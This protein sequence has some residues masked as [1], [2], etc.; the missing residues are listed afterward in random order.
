MSKIYSGHGIEPLLEQL[1]GVE[2]G[3]YVDIG[4]YD[5]EFISN[6][7]YFEEKGWDGICVEPNPEVFK[8]LQTKR[9]CELSNAAIWKEDTEI[10]FLVVTGYAEMLSGIMEAYD[11]RHMNRIQ[12]EVRHAGGTMNIVK[13]PAKKF[14]SVIKQTKIDLLNIDT[15]GSEIEILKN[16]DF[17]KYDIRVICIENNFNDPSF[18]TFF[19]E[20]GYKY[21]SMHAGCD[22]IYVKQ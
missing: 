9:K 10:D 20:R 13:I 8:I 16:V 1:C 5:G 17:N 19:A 11:P 4:A 14:D 15:E 3:Y 22:Q 12:N 7:K 21:H 2:K 6:T 18:H